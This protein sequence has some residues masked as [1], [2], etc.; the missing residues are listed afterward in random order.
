MGTLLIINAQ[1][2]LLETFDSNVGK[3][4]SNAGAVSTLVGPLAGGTNKKSCFQSICDFLLCR[5][6]ASPNTMTGKLKAKGY[7]ADEI[8]K[9]IFAQNVQQLITDINGFCIGLSRLQE[10]KGRYPSLMDSLTEVGRLLKI[11]AGEIEVPTI[12]ETPIVP[13][14]VKKAAEK[15]SIM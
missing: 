3:H 10:M 11:E 9:I 4:A 2:V 5:T 13:K 8:R 1:R 15:C 6:S 12:P 14:V 7:S